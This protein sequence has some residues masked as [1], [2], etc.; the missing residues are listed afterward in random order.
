MSIERVTERESGGSGEEVVVVVVVS[1]MV[2]VMVVDVSEHTKPLHVWFI[3][4]T[5]S[6]S[7]ESRN[8]HQDT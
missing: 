8:A 1:V 7:R 2:M 3:R 4:N 6:G 5:G